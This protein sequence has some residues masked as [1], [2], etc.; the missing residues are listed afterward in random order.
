MKKDFQEFAGREQEKFGPIV[1]EKLDSF[2]SGASQE[3]KCDIAMYLLT[4]YPFELAADFH[5]WAMAG[6]YPGKD[7]RKYMEEDRNGHIGMSGGAIRA[8]YDPAAPMTPEERYD[9]FSGITVM[10]PFMLLAKYTGW[11]T[12]EGRD[13]RE[14]IEG[15]L[16]KI[17]G[18]YLP[19]LEKAYKEGDEALLKAVLTKLAM[20]NPYDLLKMYYDWIT[21]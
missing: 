6:L 12:D 1:K 9:Y 3:E 15:N 8:C 2:F 4:E 20:Q 5:D 19:E 13:G 10:F 11:L 7:G 21:G 18:K 17:Q 14:F 16:S